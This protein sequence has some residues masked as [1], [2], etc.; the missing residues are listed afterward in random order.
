MLVCKGKESN[1]SNTKDPEATQYSTMKNAFFGLHFK[2]LLFSL[3]GFFTDPG[4]EK[5][6][7][8][9]IQ[10]FHLLSLFC[11]PSIQS[12]PKVLWGSYH[13][14]HLQMK[15]LRITSRLTAFPR[16]HLVGSGAGIWIQISLM[17]NHH[18]QYPKE[19]YES[20]GWRPSIHIFIESKICC[21]THCLERK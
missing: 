17:T 11:T 16:L 14:P 9:V 12:S 7:C 13:S 21:P 4:V 1:T 19:C 5:S 2:M 6:G 3:V 20:P 15:K 8:G 18:M 10:T